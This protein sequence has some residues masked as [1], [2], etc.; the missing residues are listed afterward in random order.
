[1]PLSE[2]DMAR[3]EALGHARDDFSILDDEWVPQLR[4]VDGACFFLG[5]DGKCTVYN[6]RPEGCRLYPLV[7]DRDAGRVIRD[8]FCPWSRE[9]A[10]PASSEWD[11]MELLHTIRHEA[12]ARQNRH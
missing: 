3:L 2:G 6:D 10:V 9:F 12:R 8:D 5:A 4:V 1:M 11:L 7:W